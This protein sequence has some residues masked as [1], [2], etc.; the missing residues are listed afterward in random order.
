ML[1]IVF[2]GWF[3]E[4]SYIGVSTSWISFNCLLSGNK[5][6]IWDTIGELLGIECHKLN[7]HTPFMIHEIGRQGSKIQEAV[8]F[9]G[10]LVFGN[11][12]DFCP[13]VGPESM[14]FAFHFILHDHNPTSTQT[15]FHVCTSL[16]DYH[17]D[18][19]KNKLLTTR[20]GTAC[21]SSSCGPLLRRFE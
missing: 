2:I 7:G 21:L 14:L 9:E 15:I 11:Y 5:G 12:T 3:Y 18:T 16:I 8:V 6:Y 10:F 20:H 4:C 1:R 19:S 17:N 13:L